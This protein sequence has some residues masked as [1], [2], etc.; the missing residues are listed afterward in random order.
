MNVESQGN[1][2]CG[3]RNAELNGWV[4]HVT[5]LAVTFRIPHSQ[6]RIGVVG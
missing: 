1:A 5:T 3:M 2:E 4:V 6:F